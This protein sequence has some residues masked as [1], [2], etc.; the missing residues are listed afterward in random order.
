M[1]DPAPVLELVDLVCIHGSGADALRAVDGV[2]L[3]IPPGRT[4]GLVG[5]SG[6]GKSTLARA[7]AGLM[8]PSAGAVRIDGRDWPVARLADRRARARRVQM[9]FQDPFGSLNPR[10]SVAQIVG[11]PLVVH[12]MPDVDRKVSALLDRVG[13]TEAQGRRYP[14]ELSGGQRQRVA[15]ARA[16]ALDPRILVCDEPVSALDVSIQAQVLNLLSDLQRDLGLAYLFISHDLSVIRYVADRIAVMYR[17]RIV[18]EGAS[19]AVWTAPA[20]PYTRALIAAIPGADRLADL[21][22]AVPP[23]AERPGACRFRHR[24]PLVQEICDT[25][26]GLAAVGPDHRAACHLAPRA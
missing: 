11:E 16:L 14:H 2:T 25:E 10:L 3:S 22:R 21:P 13:L 5:E 4:L 17:G 26:P 15:I 24:C 12:R 1:A 19:D 6:C 20:H 18:E 23:G 9:V 7:V 8:A